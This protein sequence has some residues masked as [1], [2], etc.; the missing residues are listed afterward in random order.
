[1]KALLDKMDDKDV[2]SVAMTEDCL[3]PAIK[4]GGPEEVRE[5]FSRFEGA[6]VS[7]RGGKT[8]KV[9]LTASC[10]SKDDAEKLEKATAKVSKVIIDSLPDL[11][12]EDQQKA[13]K[14]L[15]EAVKV[16]RKDAVVT[17]TGQITEDD[18][19]KLFPE[20]EKK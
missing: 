16:S 10:K 14:G 5:W 15:V 11:L 13:A 1:M 6:A 9:T 7:V 19:K 18:A 20:P 4:L 8:V 12:K 17:L 3:H 2:A